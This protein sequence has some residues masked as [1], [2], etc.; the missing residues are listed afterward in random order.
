MN[1]LRDRLKNMK[2][3]DIDDPEGCPLCGAIAGVCDNYPECKKE[4]PMNNLRD[5]I[6]IVAETLAEYNH[7]VSSVNILDDFELAKK[8][9][10]ALHLPQWISVMDCLPEIHTP[11]L[12]WLK[13]EDCNVIQTAVMQYSG[14]PEQ[15]VFYYA[16]DD[17]TY[18][19]ISEITHWMPLPEPPKE[20]E[21]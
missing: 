10:E 17:T 18:W 11:I 3:P 20:G 2:V 5:Q 9:V 21:K 1:N 19:T 8:I 6:E 7:L 15:P 14:P 16:D 12:V 13:H 4:W